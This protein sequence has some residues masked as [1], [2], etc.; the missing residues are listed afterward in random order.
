[1]NNGATKGG[2]PQAWQIVHDSPGL[3]GFWQLHTA[4]KAGADH[5][6]PDNFIANL[7]ESTGFGI[8]ISADRDGGFTVT[9]ERNQQS[10]SYKAR[11]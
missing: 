2:S 5:N 3:E 4:T 11:K 10:Q 6:V 7:D 8:S 1:M 9:N